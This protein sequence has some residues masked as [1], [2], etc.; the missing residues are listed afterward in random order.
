MLR[1]R[2]GVPT[3][4]R[5]MPARVRRLRHATGAGC[6]PLRRCCVVEAADYGRAARST[7]RLAPPGPPPAQRGLVRKACHGPTTHP[8]TC[9]DWRFSPAA[10]ELV[11]ACA[12]AGGDCSTRGARRICCEPGARGYPAHL[13][14][15]TRH[16]PQPAGAQDFVRCA[17]AG[18]APQPG[19][20]WLCTAAVAHHPR[21]RQSHDRWSRRLQAHHMVRAWHVNDKMH[22]FGRFRPVTDT[23]DT[24]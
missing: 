4:D 12:A 1:A 19:A 10:R 23:G 15:A 13:A 9:T 17:S 2:L 16:R 24:P 5:L 11:Q 18:A 6:C 14:P 7:C 3:V 8:R 22:A 20:V 21:A